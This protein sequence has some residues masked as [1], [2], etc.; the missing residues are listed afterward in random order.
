MSF[1]TE[2]PEVMLEAL[3]IL[4]RRAGGSV[5]IRDDSE[6]GPFDL[7]SKFDDDGLHLVLDETLTRE[8]VAR[9]NAGQARQDS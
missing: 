9:I 4:V 2:N 3:A 5:T 7:L 1:L 6:I 8:D